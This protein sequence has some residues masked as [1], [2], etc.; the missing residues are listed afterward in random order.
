[1]VGLHDLVRESNRDFS[2]KIVIAIVILFFFNVLKVLVA[3]KQYILLQCFFNS[4]SFSYKIQILNKIKNT[5]MLV[6]HSKIKNKVFKKTNK[7]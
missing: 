7:I 4:E 5:T 1:M 6:F 3:I 2:D